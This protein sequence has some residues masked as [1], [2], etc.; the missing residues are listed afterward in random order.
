[1]RRGPAEAQGQEQLRMLVR[2][3]RP[4]G[5]HRHRKVGGGAHSRLPLQGRSLKLKN[6]QHGC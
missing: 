4:G 1:M 2:G 6:G 5:V 3:A